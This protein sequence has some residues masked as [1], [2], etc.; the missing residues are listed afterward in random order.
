MEGVEHHLYLTSLGNAD[1]FPHNQ[2]NRFENR[3]NPPIHLDPNKE[4]EIG[5]INCFYP[6]QYLGLAMNDYP[7]RI[8]IWAIAHVD[9][10][11]LY[12]LHTYMPRT[13]IEVGDTSYMVS[14]INVELAE[15]LKSN[16]KAEY[17]R[18]FSG[19]QFLTIMKRREGWSAS[20]E[21]DNAA[22]TVISAL[23]P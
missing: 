8:E 9:E 10:S 19:D 18:Y 13:N 22:M 11:R 16:M 6:K 14:V 4:Y 3:I 17:S 23:Y 7:C 5:L 20:F 12:K 2:P 1:L 15:E 21:V